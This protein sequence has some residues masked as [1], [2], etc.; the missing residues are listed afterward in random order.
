M[1]EGLKWRLWVAPGGSCSWRLSS[2]ESGNCYLTLA[3][4]ARLG[5]LGCIGGVWEGEGTRQTVRLPLGGSAVLRVSGRL[6]FSGSAGKRGR[7][8]GQL[9]R[10]EDPLEGLGEACTQCCQAHVVGLVDLHSS[11]GEEDSSGGGGDGGCCGPW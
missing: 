8:G 10:N 1:G 11:R 2:W 9:V 6:C 5:E 3:L 4:G 7:W